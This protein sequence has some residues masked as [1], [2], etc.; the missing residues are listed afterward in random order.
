MHPEMGIGCQ[1]NIH[2]SSYGTIDPMFHQ[3]FV[4]RLF[5]MREMGLFAEKLQCIQQHTADQPRHIV[6][7]W[8]VD[9]GRTS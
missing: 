7:P 2:D 4:G 9:Y 6:K 8:L 3:G 1:C 5:D